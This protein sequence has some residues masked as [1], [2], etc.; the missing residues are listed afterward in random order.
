MNTPMKKLVYIILFATVALFFQGCESYFD[1][2]PKG[3][4][5]PTYFQDY[6]KLMNDRS[7]VGVATIYPMYLTD[8]ILLLDKSMSGGAPNYVFVNH[9]ENEQN[10]YSFKSGQ[11][12]TPGQSD[13]LWNGLYAQIFN[14]NAIIDGVMNVTD[15]TEAEKLR[16]RSEALV[17]RAFQYFLLVNAYGRH[18]DKQTAATDYGVP[19]VDTS[20]IYYKYKRNTVAEVYQFIEND[21]KEAL[22]NLKDNVQFATYPCK[23]AVYSFFARIYLYKGEYDKALENAKLAL[24]VKSTLYDYKPYV[25]TTKGM[26]WGRIQLPNNGPA[27]YYNLDNPEC[28]FL[29]NM[30]TQISNTSCISH[31][32]RDVFT[33]DLPAGSTDMRR[34]L[35][36]AD[37]KVNYGGSLTTFPGETTFGPWIDIN[38]GFTTSENM[39]IAAECEARIG[40]KDN[41]MQYINTLRNYRIKNNVALTAANND[42]A[43]LK[44][45]DERRR[46]LAFVGFNRLFDLKRLNKD[47]KFKKTI[48]HT[49]EGQSYT[50][51]PNDNRY[52]MPICDEILRFNPDMPQYQR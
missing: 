36:Y 11:L 6:Q 25:V 17:A 37:D 41:A 20:Y 52:I 44:V 32:L 23:S 29:R 51:E 22:P 5:I 1:V 15:A 50:L 38:I 21:L 24:A 2:K 35:F 10:A 39:L 7:L 46:E 28:V 40:S 42:E 16:L 34:A 31:E 49:V 3:M 27:F 45:L 9:S 26:T 48:T 33:R 4:T 47:A 30:G 18:Y 14:Y 19:I 12:F 13:N 8:D 43:L